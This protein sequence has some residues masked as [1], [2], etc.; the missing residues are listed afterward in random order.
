[1]RTILSPT[2]TT[3][4][5]Q[6]SKFI[7]F[8]FP[9]TNMEMVQFHLDEIRKNYPD[10]THHC[11]AYILKNEKRCSDDGEPSGTAGM[12][13]L[14]VL[15]KQGLNFILCIVVRYFG[16]VLLGA[17]G[18]V[19]AYTTSA[20]K[21]LSSCSYVDMVEGKEIQITFSYE[22]QKYIDPL[23][24]NVTIHS[25]QYQEQIKYNISISTD[26]WNSI[27]NQILPYLIDYQIIKDCYC[28]ENTI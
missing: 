20:T 18:L 25:K 7:G 21:T 6:K 9:V 27:L 16:G 1:M 14:N 19:R 23:L 24:K 5:I 13:I 26:I 10:A 15:E 22:N 17:G 12:P 2:T 4:E 28:L 11:Y 8:L 3:Y